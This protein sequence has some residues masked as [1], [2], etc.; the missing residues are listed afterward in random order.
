LEELEKLDKLFAEEAAAA[1][2]SP[3]PKGGAGKRGGG[4]GGGD[5]WSAL[6]DGGEDEG[7]VDTE[8]LLRD[9]DLEELDAL[10]GADAGGEWGMG[11]GNAG[12][13]GKKQ[14]PASAAASSSSSSKTGGKGLSAS[15]IA[16]MKVADLK[17]ELKA[18]GLPVTGSKVEL[19]A[20]LQGTA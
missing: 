15:A 16:G 2:K 9:L 10:M 6:L 18:R 17:A 12:A 8:A 5:D 11:G 7:D 1:L 3:K 4:L 14:A 19:Q 13:K 20:R